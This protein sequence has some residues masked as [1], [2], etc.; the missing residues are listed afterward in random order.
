[1]IPMPQARIIDFFVRSRAGVIRL[2][3]PLGDLDLG[4]APR[5]RRP[6]SGRY[7]APAWFRSRLTR[8]PGSGTPLTFRS[9]SSSRIWASHMW[10]AGSRSPFI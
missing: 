2:A 4:P 7:R 10:L 6:G 5:A 8:G 3:E 9:P 1:M